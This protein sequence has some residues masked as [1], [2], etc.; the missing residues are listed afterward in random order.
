M[1]DTVLEQDVCINDACPVDEDGAVGDGDGEVSAAE[2][3]H[4]A[5]G[6]GAG[7]G[8]CAVNDVVL[9]DAGGLLDG[10]VAEGRGDVLEGGVVGGEDGEI[11]G[12]VYGRGEV[13]GVQGA[14]EGG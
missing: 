10:E 7:V 13:G 4:G 8:Y 9:E 3:G 11:R 1:E 5:V 14:E 12:V 2:G 6:E